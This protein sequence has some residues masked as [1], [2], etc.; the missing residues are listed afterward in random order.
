MTAPPLPEVPPEALRDN[1]T[2]ARV[3]RIWRRLETDVRDGRVARRPAL[4]WAPVA[5]AVV[6][7]AGVFVG[8]QWTRLNHSE[9]AALGPE[10]AVI[11]EQEVARAEL[12]P[13]A[14]TEVQQETRPVPRTPSSRVAPALVQPEAAAHENAVEAEAAPVPAPLPTSLP[15]WQRLFDMGE[16]DAARSE[17]DRNGG[18][19]NGFDAALAAASPEHAVNLADIAVRAGERARAVRA[20]ER[21]V[22]SYSSDPIAPLAAYKLGNLLD[23]MGNRSGAAEA[24][25][26]YRRLSPTGDL[27]E[28][29]LARQVDVAIER[30]DFEAARR[31]A[32]QY[33]KDF[34]KG[35]RLAEFRERLQK[36]TGAASEEASDAGAPAADDLPAEEPADDDSQRTR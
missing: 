13:Q 31:L 22:E 6:F 30:G 26:N 11:P 19:A 4:W 5:A 2:S 15:E 34:P 29:A 7:G 25:A 17:L 33:A 8:V 16:F 9:E 20:L 18:F 27:A 28:D 32:D 23:K 24:F 3:D 1:A 14:N 21:V 35:R 10:P 36:L 12:Q